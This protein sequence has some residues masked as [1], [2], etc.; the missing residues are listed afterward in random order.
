VDWALGDA[1]ARLGD[2]FDCGLRLVPRLIPNHLRR[3]LRIAALA[4]RGFVCRHIYEVNKIFRLMFLAFVIV[5]AVKQAAILIACSI[6][7][8]EQH[9]ILVETEGPDFLFGQ[10]G[11]IQHQPHQVRLVAVV[12]V[13]IVTVLDELISIG[14]GG[15][16][17]L[18]CLPVGLVPQ[19]VVGV[20]ARQVAAAHPVGGEALHRGV[21]HGHHSEVLP[22]VLLLD[23][24]PVP[25]IV[26][27]TA[28]VVVDVLLDFGVQL[29]QP[30]PPAALPLSESLLESVG[31]SHGNREK[32]C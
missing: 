30:A 31:P 19:D 20:D 29:S 27:E 1:A 32:V 5:L 23:M 24:G 21:E 18:E 9:E 11:Q 3:A 8:S 6:F 12:A 4:H 15:C 13:V 14:N 22:A 26:I 7:M 2:L 16:D 10:E 25:V 28:P 17:V